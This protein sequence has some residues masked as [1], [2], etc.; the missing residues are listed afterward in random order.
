[1]SESEDNDSLKKMKTNNSID[2]KAKSLYCISDTK[3]I[4]IELISNAV[5]E[6]SKK[7][8]KTTLYISIKCLSC[9]TESSD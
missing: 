5:N 8:V 1:M 4:I 6:S 7:N 3:R 2:N 9:K